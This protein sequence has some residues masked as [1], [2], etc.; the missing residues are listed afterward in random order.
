MRHS[1]FD[2]TDLDTISYG[3]W[4]HVP[5]SEVAEV[6][7]CARSTVYEHYRKLRTTDVEKRGKQPRK[8]H[9]YSSLMRVNIAKRFLAGE[10]AIALAHEV[11]CD[12]TNIYYWARRYRKGSQV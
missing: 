7:G 2:S 5:A 12:R 3:Y 8:T 11:G 6:L 1:T 4:H 10:S 9:R